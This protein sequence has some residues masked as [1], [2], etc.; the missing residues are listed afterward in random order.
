MATEY[1][2]VKDATATDRSNSV[3]GDDSPFQNNDL[4]KVWLLTYTNGYKPSNGSLEYHI[5][6]QQLFDGKTRT[7]ANKVPDPFALEDMRSRGWDIV[8]KMWLDLDLS[9]AD[10]AALFEKLFHGLYMLK[11]GLIQEGRFTINSIATDTVFTTSIKQSLIS[12]IDLILDD[13][14]H[15]KDV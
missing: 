15:L 4:G 5:D 3:H 6:R 8:W 7:N 10:R 12:N 13:Y 9:V 1:Y 11:W 14:P 2:Y